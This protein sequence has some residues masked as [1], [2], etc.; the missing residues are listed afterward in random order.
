LPSTLPGNGST[1]AGVHEWGA[2]RDQVLGTALLLLLIFALTDTLNTPPG[3]NL[4]P[5][6]IGLV[7]VATGMAF[8]AN[9]GYAIN[10]ARDFG[11]RLASFLTGYDSAW[12]DQWGTLHFWVP[13][14]GPLV[15]G[16][17]GSGFY[18]Y[19]IGNFLPTT[20]SEPRACACPRGVT[21]KTAAPPAHRSWAAL[22]RARL[23]IGPP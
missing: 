22:G 13:I 8:G 18:Q 15:G 9:A 3:A 10:P 5:L 11:P 20:Q 23:Q 6:I 4:A 16:V 2:F 12:R 19:V 14:V 21:T 17:I 1:T 7:V